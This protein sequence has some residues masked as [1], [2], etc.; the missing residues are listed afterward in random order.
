MKRFLGFVR[1]VQPKFGSSVSSNADFFRPS[2]PL[3][4]FR[5]LPNRALVV[6]DSV[7]DLPV[8]ILRRKPDSPVPLSASS[9]PIREKPHE[10]TDAIESSLCL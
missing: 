4:E 1:F 3:Y 2:F 6:K 9:L 8:K 10:A 5:T 7:H